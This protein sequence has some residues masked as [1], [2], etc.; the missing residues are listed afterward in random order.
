MR[1][2]ISCSSQ[3]SIDEIYKEKTKELVK[4]IS[5]SNDLVFGSSNSGLMKICY[6]EF[7]KNNRKVIGICYEIYKDLLNDLELDETIL[8]KSLN[9]SNDELIKNSDIILVLPGAYGTLSE[10]ISSIELIRT[11]VYDKK[12]VIYNINGF[13]NDLFK[14]FEKMYD[15][16]TT[17]NNYN[18]II[19]ICNTKEEVINNI[20]KMRG[21]EI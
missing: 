2:F 13:Y 12:I 15:S 16:K 14:L 3:D 4:A 8:V 19:K 21:E 17:M 5:V 10:T 6:D 11:K 7:K 18:E 9:E 1:I 20:S